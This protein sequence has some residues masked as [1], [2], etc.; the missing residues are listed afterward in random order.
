M[1]ESD[2]QLRDKLHGRAVKLWFN[3][4]SDS[5]I[6]VWLCACDCCRL[7]VEPCQPGDLVKTNPRLFLK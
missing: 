5:S 3:H 4:Q 6:L 7:D 1:R 2:E